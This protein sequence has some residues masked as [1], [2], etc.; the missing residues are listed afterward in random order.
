MIAQWDSSMGQLSGIAS[1]LSVLSVA[2]GSIP[3]YGGVFQGIFPW[4]ITCAGLYTVQGVPKSG[5]APLGKKPL[6]SRRS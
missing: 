3:D 2:Q 5:V 1:S 4:L 6:V